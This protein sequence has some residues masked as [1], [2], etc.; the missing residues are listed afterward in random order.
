MKKK[1]T[2]KLQKSAYL[3]SQLITLKGP[4][5]L[6]LGRS[7]SGKSSLLNA[8]FRKDL[9]KVSKTPGKTRSVNYYQYGS[10]LNLVDFPGYGYAKR[11]QS[12]KALWHELMK[13]FFDILPK[14]SWVFIL[15][16]AKRDLGSEEFELIDNF[17][18]N[19]HIVKLLLTKADRLN[20]SLR[21]KRTDYLTSLIKEYGQN[22][23]AWSFVSVKTG[24]GISAT[25][26]DLQTYETNFAL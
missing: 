4:V 8:V 5:A 9:A 15:S 12:E 25:Y 2:I 18:G 17:S 26:Q 7:N 14:R 1:P 6:F 22:I 10:K 11:S 3:S 19:G 24:E 21:K 20:Q 23:L 13:S 16:D